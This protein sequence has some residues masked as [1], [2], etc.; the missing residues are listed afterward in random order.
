[1]SLLVLD[2]ENNLKFVLI[3]PEEGDVNVTPISTG[4]TS[5]FIPTVAISPRYPQTNF[6]YLATKEIRN[7]LKFNITLSNYLS[8]EDIVNKSIVFNLSNI[9]IGYHTFTYR[10]DS[11][12][13][14]IT[15]FVDGVKYT[16]L[17]IS[18]GKYRIQNIF[19]DDFFV[20]ST[21]FYNGVDLAT[22]LNQPGYYF[23]KDLQIKNFF[24]YDRALYDGEIIALNL[25]DKPV[26]DII[27]SLPYGQRNNIEEIERVFKYSGGG[28]SKS[29]SINVKNLNIQSESFRN[30]IRNIILR[31]AKNILPAGISVNDIVFTD[32]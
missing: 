19:A 29:V 16:N 7:S 26:S 30:N 23:I 9:D 3:Q 31:D 8:A 21:G 2:T 20:G 25:Y 17:T 6:N 4:L 15:L 5:A 12:Q 13:G 32:T 27:L 1:M 18:P 24:L 22:Y 10:F 28:S 11:I 14:N